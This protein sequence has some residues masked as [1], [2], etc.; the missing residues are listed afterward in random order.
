MFLASL[1]F[2]NFC[3]VLT[4]SS[5]SPTSV[6]EIEDDI[7]ETALP[8]SSGSSNTS[9]VTLNSKSSDEKTVKNPGKP[10]SLE[11]EKTKLI[12]QLRKEN[13]RLNELLA[14]KNQTPN[15]L[16]NLLFYF[17]ISFQDLNR[18]K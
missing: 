5:S 3:Y 7:G 16:G 17:R 18:R 10:R 4:A 2:H 1:I 11:D 14:A 12:D 13:Q 15:S 6:I 9:D 8:N